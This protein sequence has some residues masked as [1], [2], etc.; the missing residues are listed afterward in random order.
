MGL[1]IGS[2][3]DYYTGAWAGAAPAGGSAAGTIYSS[4]NYVSLTYS[5]TSGTYRDWQYNYTFEVKERIATSSSVREIGANSD[6]YIGVTDDVIV[7][8]AIAVRAVNKKMLDLLR[9]GLG[10]KTMVNGHEYNVTGT[11]EVLA[12]GWDAE[13]QDSVFLVRDE[14]IQF[15]TKVN[16]TFIHSQ[17]YITEELIPNLL[18]TRN[19][20]LLDRSATAQYAQAL[21]DSQKK[22][23]Y[24]SKLDRIDEDFG[25]GENNYT[26][27][28]PEGKPR[29]WNDTI[30]ALNN[31]ISTWA[32]F[33]ATNEKQKLEAAEQVKV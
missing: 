5:L 2:G 7:E 9:P 20:L 24:V 18:R 17:H 12:R 15:I 26:V 4:D 8:D 1:D 6:L 29:N 21:A 27:Y 19:D 13:K 25:W 28:Y 3:S 16:S 14:V 23:V 22:P 30:Q 11:T 10:G 32:G 31:E 33:V